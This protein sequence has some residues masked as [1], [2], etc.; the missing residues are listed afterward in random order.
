M[1]KKWNDLP[2]SFKNPEVNF[3]YEILN[4]KR[5]QLFFKR[6]FDILI[7]L[8][9]LILLSPIMIIIAIS[10][11]LDSKGPVFFRQRRITQYGKT[12]RIFKFRTMVENAEK[13]GSQVTVSNDPR[14]TKIGGFI[15]KYRI[16]EF[17][18]LLNVLFGDMTFVGTRPEVKKYV[19]AYTN[20]MLATLLL[21]AGIT[22]EASIKYK[23]EQRLLSSSAD[24]DKTYIEEILPEKMKYNLKGI[25]KTSIKYDLSIMLATVFGVLR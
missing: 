8:I 16:D 7:S 14:V 15:R 4:K 10:I 2:D 24:A 5:A 12:F 13:L 3:Y 21:P 18:Q 23:D 11:K 22:S 20:E 25:E 17:P 19:D 6:L 9:L 1:L